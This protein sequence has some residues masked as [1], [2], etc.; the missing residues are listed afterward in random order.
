MRKIVLSFLL[1]IALIIQL[2]A[3]VPTTQD[4]MGA[5]PVCQNVY[6]QS[7]SYSNSGNYPNEIPT[8]QGC[9]G[10]CLAA[11]E[12]NDVWYTFTVQQSGNLS[13]LITPNNTADD[14]DWA[15]Y[16]LTNNSCGDIYSNSAL[17]VSCNFSAEDGTTGANGGSGSNCLDAVD[18]RYNAVIPVVAG[19]TY[20][21][22]VSNYSSSQ[23]G[24]TLDFGAST[25]VIFDNIPPFIQSLEAIPSCGATTIE[26]NFS[27]NVLCNTVSA[28]DFS[29]T[30]PGGPYTVTNVTGNACSLGGTQEKT[31]TITVSPA[32]T[33]SGN[34]QICLNGPAVAGS[35]SDLCGNIAPAG[36]LDFTVVNITLNLTSV[37]ENCGAGDGSATVTATGGSGTYTY[38]WNTTPVQ[39]TQTA[40]NLTS[41]T[42]TVTVSDGACT[43]TGSVT[44]NSIGGPS[45][46][47][48]GTDEDCGQANGTATVT[49]T[50]GTGSYTY[51]WS[52]T[53]VQTNPIAT[54]LT[55]GTYTVTVD[56]GGPC[57]SSIS[58][59]IG[60]TAGPTL[61][62]VSMTP[63]NAGASD[64]SATVSASG[65]TSPYTY[66]WNTTPPQTGPTATN[67]AAGTYT[68]TVEDDNGCQDVITVTVTSTGGA[69][70]TL[71]QV[72]AHCG[73]D[74]GSATVVVNNPV[75]A[76]TLIWS[77]GETTETINNLT[78]GTYTVTV[79]DDAG[80]YVQ[81]IYVSSYPGPEAEF[82]A[83]PNPGTL[84][85]DAI[86]FT[87]NSTGGTVY[88]W[89]FGDGSTST[90]ENPSH[91]YNSIGNYTVW[92]I[93]YDDYGCIDSTSATI[94]IQD[95]F[96]LYIPNA[97]SPNG[98]GINDLFYP[99]G[100]G[101][102]T[103]E[104]ELRI[105][106]R[107]GQMVFFSTTVNQ[108]WDGNLNEK[109]RNQKPV[110]TYT[111]TLDFK[112]SV[113]LP[114]RIV[115]SV[116]AIY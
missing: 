79:T 42:Y 54:G 102:D 87:N 111:Y 39:T 33:A 95:V 109:I 86:F 110:N 12:T 58:I 108:G 16:N 44:I 59:T 53:P 15:V 115:G 76:Y 85:E 51:S 68:V 99:Q 114:H 67:L 31:Y 17:Q 80:T 72:P 37:D 69:T 46:T 29:V 5:I 89:S 65:G 2:S 25:A 101:V 57:P 20:V 41:G 60:G 13:F 64:G 83:A 62:L 94:I 70:L 18:G 88:F 22:N 77:N 82:H 27:E 112:D 103:E 48:V 10:H 84:G 35:V 21:L 90:N 100:M 61:S 96:T 75:G 50:G 104:Y 74:N 28:A 11:G 7:N 71:S 49:A 92:L 56:D 47:I 9:P 98:D 52:T 55:T 91:L 34:Y 116:T 36:C 19:Q 73:Q 40:N 66:T 6:S 45:L 81:G 107:W 106:D 24:Y 78:S 8:G 43:A 1:L 63:E 14:Y 23:D 4:C 3:Q 105:F 30:G 26:F 38:S 32:I 113:G 93:V 97:F